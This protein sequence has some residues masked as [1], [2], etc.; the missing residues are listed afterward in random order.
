LRPLPRAGKTHSRRFVFT[1]S[2]RGLPYRRL[3]WVLLAPV[4]FLLV[5]LAERFPAVTEQV[6]SLRVYP[7]LS[8]S[9][10][11]LTGLLPFSLVEIC[12]YLCIVA[13]VVYLATA[14]GG[15]ARDKANRRDRVI[16][17]VSTIACIG[18]LWYSAS[19]L[20]CGFNYH[21]LSF[22]E[23]SGLYVRNSSV[24]EL[25]AL[26][27]ELVAEANTLR[28]RMHTTENGIMATSFDSY[29][30]QGRFAGESYGALAEA[31]PMLGGYTPAAKPVL[32]SRAMSHMNIVGIFIPFTYECNIN[33]DVPDYGIPS[34]MMHELSHFKGFMREDEANYLAW[35]ACRASGNE[36]FAYSG[37]MLALIHSTN[38]L[39]ATNK[40]VYNEV[41]APLSQDVW[42]DMMD[43]SYYWKQFE[44]PVSEVSTAV[45]NTYLRANKQADGVKSYGRM[46]DLLLAE[47]RQR[48]GLV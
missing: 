27:S 36:E 2:R 5:Q 47:Y 39:Y 20:F 7:V 31:Y 10:G 11:R 12:I 13:A 46:V 9:I 15:I 24:E 33:T 4:L 37:T 25:A 23:Y 38:A 14:I 44:G 16:R 29:Y 18:S 17:F 8:R 34:S 22:T 28:P 19:T 26:C 35:L 43:N 21:R 45:N 42:N 30:E 32:A 41:M 6:Y 1:Q 3:Y 40:E 48:H